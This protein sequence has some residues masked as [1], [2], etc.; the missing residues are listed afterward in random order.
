MLISISMIISILQSYS[1]ILLQTDNWYTSGSNGVWLHT[2]QAK[3]SVVVKWQMML[4]S[5]Y[6]DINVTSSLI[7]WD[8][9]LPMKFTTWSSVPFTVGSTGT[10]YMHEKRENHSP[11]YPSGGY[12]SPLT[13]QMN[14]SCS[15]EF[16]C[17]NVGLQRCHNIYWM[18]PDKLRQYCHDVAVTLSQYFIVSAM[19]LQRRCNVVMLFRCSLQH[20]A[21]YIETDLK[22][23]LRRLYKLKSHVKRI[24]IG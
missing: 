3:G 9:A 14:F 16:R 22:Y 7:G 4:R 18:V 23:T 10:V 5:M 1:K 12:L 21:N 19:L 6:Y 13:Q 24:L 8:L 11:K 17:G 2:P 20:M 15:D